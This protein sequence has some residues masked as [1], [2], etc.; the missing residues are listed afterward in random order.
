MA[1]SMPPH[2]P[3]SGK[4]T[5]P[6]SWSVAYTDVL[7]ACPAMVGRQGPCGKSTDQPPS[8]GETQHPEPPCCPLV[9]S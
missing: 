6:E 1:A 4:D 9:R 5:A 7:A 8:A 2:G 3:A